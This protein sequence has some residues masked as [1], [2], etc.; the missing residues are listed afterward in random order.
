MIRNP[1]QTSGSMNDSSAICRE[2]NRTGDMASTAPHAGTFRWRRT[3]YPATATA[4]PIRCCT[5]TTSGRLW[6]GASKKSSMG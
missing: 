6:N 2:S 3:T 5:E 1:Y 4:I